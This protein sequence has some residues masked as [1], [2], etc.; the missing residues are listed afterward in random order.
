MQVEPHL[1]RAIAF[2]DGQNLYHAAKEA[3]GYTYPNYDILKLSQS[4]CQA[5]GWDLVQARF[6]TGIPD[7]A[8]D[9]HWH[10]FW[11]GKLRSMSWQK[12]HIFS[13]R[14]RYRNHRVKMPDGTEHTFMAAEEKGIDVRMAIDI[15]RMAHHG[16]YDVA[17]IF[18]QDQDLS[19]VA[20]EVRVMAA[21]QNRWIKVASAFPFSSVSHNS[22]G[23]NK[24]D[25]IK[26]DRAMY[27]ACLDS[28]NYRQTSPPPSRQ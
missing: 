14:L 26:I 27:D 19:E 22:R 12:V 23:I 16:E 25:W 4:V 3:F 1:K 21:E 15:I 18:S 13:R 28:H 11:T 7:V 20:D 6:Y 2:V 24:T 17:V 8:D 9:P 10:I 5:K